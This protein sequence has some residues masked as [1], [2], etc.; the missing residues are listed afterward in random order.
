MAKTKTEISTA[1]LQQMRIVGTDETPAASDTAVVQ[2]RY[3]SKLAEWRD[4]GLVWWPNTDA[5]TAEIP[6][7]VAAIITDLMENETAHVFGKGLRTVAERMAQEDI[8]LRR[9]YRMLARL[10]SGEP[11][12]F[13]VF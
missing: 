4:K 1:T 8:I 12:Q 5:V 10:P 2:N 13:S 6:D 11:T 7:E 9:L 3:D